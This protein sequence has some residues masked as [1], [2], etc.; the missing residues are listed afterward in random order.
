MRTYVRA[1]CT[2]SLKQ[3]D[4]TREQAERRRDTNR[5]TTSERQS[6]C[7][8]AACCK[9]PASFQ[10][11]IKIKIKTNIFFYAACCK[12]P[13]RF[14]KNPKHKFVTVFRRRPIKRSIDYHTSLVTLDLPTPATAA[15]QCYPPR[16]RSGTRTCTAHL[17]TTSCT[18]D[19]STRIPFLFQQ[20]KT[21]T[22]TRIQHTRDQAR[23]HTHTVIQIMHTRTH[24]QQHT[25][26][27][28]THTSYG[29]RK[30][31]AKCTHAHGYFIHT[32]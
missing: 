21:H 2:V 26:N 11:K 32:K 14:S 8:Y 20:E 28:H 27:G 1:S 16:R 4:R 25:R 19:R 23:A 5:K 22:R 7:L 3:N 24:M 17:R 30:I 18:P 9:L 12:L 6:H 31:N 13:V 29:T 10:P 15:Q